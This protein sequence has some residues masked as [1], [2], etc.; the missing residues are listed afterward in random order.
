MTEPSSEE[1]DAEGVCMKV[2]DDGVT[3]EDAQA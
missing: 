3:K 1:E 2:P